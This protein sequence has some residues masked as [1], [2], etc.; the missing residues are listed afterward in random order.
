MV[1]PRARA[2]VWRI[3]LL[4]VLLGICWI[5]FSDQLTAALFDDAAAIT[6]WQMW[7]GVAYMV[8]TGVLLY[9]L[10]RPLVERLL[11][12]QRRI[13][14]SE[15]RYR[16]MFECNTSP[17]WTYDPESLRIVDANPAASEFL[18]WSRGELRGFK[19]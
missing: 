12:A 7:K 1:V 2:L 11:E 6:R 19:A 13:T 15:A 8:G 5:L 9:L 3:P 10:L 4:Y 18:G 17:M 16:E 14:D